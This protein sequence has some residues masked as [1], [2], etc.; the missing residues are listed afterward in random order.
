M[1][2]SFKRIALI[3]VILLFMPF[4]SSGQTQNIRVG[5]WQAYTGHF[6]CVRSASDGGSIFTITQGGMFSYEI[7]SKELR[8]FSTVNQMSDIRPGTIYYNSP[9]Q[10]YF[11]GYDDG[12]LDYFSDPEQITAITD[13]ERSV[14][15]T[16][17]KI[18]D[19]TGDDEYL[20]V[21][22]EFG[23][24][25]FDLALMEPKFSVT[26][27]GNSLVRS[28]INAVSLF[29]DRVWI[30]VGDTALFSAPAQTPNP[31]DPSIWVKET[32]A[33]NFPGGNI[34]GL[35]ADDTHIYAI[36]NGKVYYSSGTEWLLF[37]V[38]GSFFG[39]YTIIR[40]SDDKNY[41]IIASPGEVRLLEKNGTEKLS[42][43]TTGYIQDVYYKD[44]VF[45]VATFYEGAYRFENNGTERI[46]IIPK[47]PLTNDCTELAAGNGELYIA[48][49]G[50]D[51]TFAPTASSSGIHYFNK[52]TT[53]SEN[54]GWKNLKGGDG[55]PQN[56][57]NWNYARG[58]YDDETGYAFMGSF[59]KGL[60]KLKNGVLEAYYDCAN[61]GITTMENP[62]D[63]T[64]FENTRVSGVDIDWQ[65]NIWITIT[66]A[67]NPLQTLA[68]D[69]NWYNMRDDF[70]SSSSQIS[71]L[72]V[73]DYTN[74]W[75][76]VRRGGL[77]VYNDKGTLA[78]TADDVFVRLGA[79]PGQGDLP[80]ANVY[81]LARDKEGDVWIGT[82]E[83]VRIMY[84]NFLYDLSNGQSADVRAPIL[85]GYP[86]LRTESINAIAVDGGNR[87]WLGTNNGVFLVS[88]DGQ[89]IIEYFTQKN[90]PLPS[91]IIT[92]I[93]IDNSTG[94]V[95]FATTKGVVSYRSGITTGKQECEEVLVFPNPVNSGYDGYITITGL[96]AESV[97]KITTVSGSLV[98]ELQG[99]GG[100]AVWDGTDIQGKKVASGVYLAF[101][102][103]SNGEKSCVGK[104]TVVK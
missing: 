27:V 91:D 99:E 78:N 38:V 53:Y 83:G 22:T 8:S 34:S 35:E 54:S 96:S 77:I 19:I 55:L 75:M 92:D 50:Y 14:F 103:N 84:S 56:R 98:R 18:Y 32:A 20:Y 31:G 64:R 24:V 49:L 66:L 59:G 36:V 30:S 97:V 42:F 101:A 28:K 65:R 11:L 63:T 61:S 82:D 57:A 48:P 10:Q 81:S 47:G 94:E 88:A 26:K 58:V 37:P 39:G 17:K 70:I 13:I 9:T 89:E 71:G 60:A 93:S 3:S 25:I 100:S 29:K 40:E 87:K 2:I 52:G 104:F 76:M 6:Q 90:T 85:D 72:L 43:Q 69:G 95:F 80:S 7:S 51:A 102:A 16:Q 86:L 45:Y 1:G 23:M 68:A 15:Y 73:D 74:K 4:F 62:C 46:S 5:E 44:N 21:A 12:T 33:N 67:Q 41:F 79:N